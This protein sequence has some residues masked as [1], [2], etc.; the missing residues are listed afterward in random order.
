MRLHAHK[1]LQ[2]PADEAGEPDVALQADETDAGLARL[3]HEPVLDGIV[4]PRC[5]ATDPKCGPV[6]S[7][8]WDRPDAPPHNQTGCV[9]GRARLAAP[10]E[11]TPGL[12]CTHDG[13]C[14]VGACGATCLRWDQPLGPMSCE[15]PG[16]I[17]DQ[18]VTYCGCVA[19]R[20]DWF[21]PV[22]P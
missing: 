1:G 19:G 13:E 20:C 14:L 15:E 22:A 21:R 18:P 4:G 11:V 12:A 2:Q 5:E 10:H 16:D 7:R 9:A 6:S 17:E 8:D 3:D